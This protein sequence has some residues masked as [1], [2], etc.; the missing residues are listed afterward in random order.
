[1]VEAGV[2]QL[3]CLQED[4][5]LTRFEPPETLAARRREV[6]RRGIAFLHEPIEDFGA[7]S[8]GQAQRLVQQITAAL[9]QG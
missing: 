9:D 1:L 7:P 6:E 5:E 8:V 3:V 4:H 2:A